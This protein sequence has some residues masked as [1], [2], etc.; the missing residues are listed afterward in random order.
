MIAVV[1]MARRSSVVVSFLVGAMVFH[2]KNLKMKAIDLALILLGMFFLWLG[3][4]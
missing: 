1:S 3:T 2:E 4:S